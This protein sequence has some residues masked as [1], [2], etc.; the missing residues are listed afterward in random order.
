MH[1]RHL[2]LGLAGLLLLGCATTPASTALPAIEPEVE[3]ATKRV[4]FHYEF[5]D[6]ATGE[7]VQGSRD[8]P[9]VALIGE[10]SSNPF[11]RVLQQVLRD[12]EVGYRARMLVPA[13]ILDAG[14]PPRAPSVGDMWLTVAIE[15]IDVPKPPAPRVSMDAFA[16]EPIAVSNL[17]D[18]SQLLEYASG[19]GRPAAEGDIVELY[20]S[21][22]FDGREVGT[23]DGPTFVWIDGIDSRTQPLL[24]AKPGARR[25]VAY[26]SLT[27]YYQVLDVLR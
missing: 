17:S 23:P 14:K 5:V 19:D 21:L 25:K 26:G 20:M 6:A 22:A 11:E 16:G 9:A 2:V 10:A 15:N 8:R 3:H 4:W 12:H 7:R 1:L 27:V 13:E 18:G 24:G